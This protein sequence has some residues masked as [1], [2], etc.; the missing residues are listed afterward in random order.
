MHEET[1]SRQFRSS[2]DDNISSVTPSVTPS[3]DVAEGSHDGNQT[4]SSDQERSSHA[5]SRG[6]DGSLGVRCDLFV[7][8]DGRDTFNLW[9][10]FN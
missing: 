10:L 3:A 7:T 6:H 1:T 9:S 8:Y 4:T 2:D 5:A